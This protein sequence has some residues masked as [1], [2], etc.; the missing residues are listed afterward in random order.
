MKSRHEAK[1]YLS[2]PGNCRR[3]ESNL[4]DFPPVIE[5]EGET[6]EIYNTLHI[7]CSLEIFSVMFLDPTCGTWNFLFVSKNPNTQCR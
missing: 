6:K 5:G 4:W 2:F 1:G 7:P 3:S